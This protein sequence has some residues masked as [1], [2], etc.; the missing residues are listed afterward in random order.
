MINAFK[1]RGDTFLDCTYHFQ[2][3]EIMFICNTFYVADTE[4]IPSERIFCRENYYH[5]K[6]VLMQILGFIFSYLR[7]VLGKIKR[8]HY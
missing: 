2:L 8:Q 5:L 6:N 3:P 7:V 4:N 1:S